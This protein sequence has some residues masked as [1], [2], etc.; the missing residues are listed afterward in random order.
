MYYRTTNEINTVIQ[1]VLWTLQYELQYKKD[2]SAQNMFDSWYHCL[3]VT[4][5]CAFVFKKPLYLSG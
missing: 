3:W 5:L 4:V 1:F 2:K